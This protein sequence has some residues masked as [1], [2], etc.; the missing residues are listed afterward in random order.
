MIV[1]R[2]RLLRLRSRCMPLDRTRRQRLCNTLSARTAPPTDLHRAFIKQA[3]V[4]HRGGIIQIRSQQRFCIYLYFRS[5]NTFYTTY[6][7]DFPPES[8]ADE[9]V[10]DQ[11]R[12]SRIHGGFD[13]A[14]VGSW[15]G[16]D[17]DDHGTAAAHRL[18]DASSR[19]Q[20]N[21]R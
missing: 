13:D 20:M 2:V 9:Y 6:G 14:T 18:C 4:V 11:C 5:Y 1:P 21:G 12:Y 19:F 3:L 8:R 7:V 10:A 15:Y 16:S 17:P